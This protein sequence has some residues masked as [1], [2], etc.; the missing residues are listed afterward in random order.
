VS[1]ANI[2]STICHSGYTTTIRPPE[3]VTDAEK[4][5]S[6]AAYGYTGSLHTAEY[7]HLISL[8]L[9]GDPNDAA[10]LWVE[11]NDKPTATSTANT[12]DVIENKL[13]ELV[14]AGQITLAAAQD[15]IATNWVAAYEKYVT[16]AV[17]PP[18]TPPTAAVAAPAPV[19]AVPVAPAT[20]PSGCY[21]KTDGGNCYTAGELCRASDH[22]ASGLAGNGDSITCENNNGWRW[23]AA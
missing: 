15:D 8:E 16:T 21:P 4:R 13:N 20:T 19:A 10:N 23:E 9:G 1:Q 3:N 7:D 5:A 18:P 17:A 14:C 11:P 6:A 12:K 22:G 2:D